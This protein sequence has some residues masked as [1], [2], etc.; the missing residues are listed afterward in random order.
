MKNF[1]I[2]EPDAPES[3]KILIHP[4]AVVH[5][6]AEI[7]GS[8]QIG[9]YSVIGE[10]VRIGPQTRIGSHAVI[11][12]AEIGSA[13]QIHSHAFVGTAPQDLKYRGEKTKII[14]GDG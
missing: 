2:E 9:P 12:F 3:E 4:T 8:V 7:D 1:S 6:S 14:V 5:H 11:E 10:G 13:C